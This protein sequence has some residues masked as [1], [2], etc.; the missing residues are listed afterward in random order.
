M[1]NVYS[2]DNV[3]VVLQEEENI[4]IAFRM[5]ASFDI[6]MRQFV[7]QRYLRHAG[8]DGIHVHLAEEGSSIVDLSTRNL[9]EFR[10]QF[11]RAGAPMCF[12]NTDYHIFA[13]AEATHSF[14]QHTERLTDARR[15]AKKYLEA[16]APLLG[17]CAT[18]KPVLRRLSVCF[19]V[20]QSLSLIHISE[21]TRQAEISYAV[22]CL[23]K[24]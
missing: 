24:K 15:V 17:L 5:T 9:F 2:A 19:H 21:P 16:P 22:F 1:L 20:V 6:G 11:R 23:K 3:D 14:A 4:F 10:S 12:H 8:D 18:E 7:D 13:P